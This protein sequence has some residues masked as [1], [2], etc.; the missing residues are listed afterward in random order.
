M[1]TCVRRPRTVTKKERKK[2]KGSQQ[3][4]EWAKR[5]EEKQDAFGGSPF[6]ASLCA[7]SGSEFCKIRDYRDQKKGGKGGGRK[8]T[9]KRRKKM[10]GKNGIAEIGI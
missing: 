6:G 10:E 4:Q 2:R 8:R 1:R 7:C 5:I 3:K 9:S